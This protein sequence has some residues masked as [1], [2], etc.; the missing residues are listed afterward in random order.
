MAAADL[1]YT[2]VVCK[3]LL[4]GADVNMEVGKATALGL[5]CE[6]GHKAVAQEL[7]KA[8]ANLEMQMS[9][10]ARSLMMQ[11]VHDEAAE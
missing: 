6:E 3:L 9:E 1:G 11:L 4:A 8:K 10:G 5:A 2:A 7:I